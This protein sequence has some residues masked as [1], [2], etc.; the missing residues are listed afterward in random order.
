VNAPFRGRVAS[1]ATHVSPTA[2]GLWLAA[3]SALTTAF[4]HGLLKS[5]EDKLA[6]QAWVRLTCLALSLPVAL[7]IGFPPL[8]LVPWI[9]AA[10]AVHAVYQ[11]LL[12]WS[13]DVSDFAAAY[14]IARGIAPIS[15]ALMGIVILG[16]SLTVTLL[17]SIMVVS[18]GVMMLA[19]GGGMSRAGLAAAALTGLLT[20]AYSIVDAKGVRLADDPA[21]FIVWFFI[22]DGFSMPILFVARRR[23]QA[24][25]ILATHRKTGIVAGIMAPV[26]FVPALYAFSLA[27]VGAVAAIRETSVLVGMLVAKHWLDEVVDRKRLVAGVLIMIGAIGIVGALAQN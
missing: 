8:D 21:I 9:L 3:C 6:M 13:Y 5:G 22:A 17:G 12:S 24:F 16:E 15:T 7:L 10:A 1:K 14:P 4:A 19:R 11:A 2:I 27:P 26:S 25:A 18:I 23:R 20:M